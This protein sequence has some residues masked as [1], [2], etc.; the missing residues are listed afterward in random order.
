MTDEWVMALEQRSDTSVA[1]G[2]AAD[3]ADPVRRGADLRV[4]MT[5]DVYEETMVF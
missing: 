3:V 1:A 2:S 5:T 4:Y